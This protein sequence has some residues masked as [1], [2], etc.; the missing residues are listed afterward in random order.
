MDILHKL[1]SL[2]IKTLKKKKSIIISDYYDLICSEMKELKINCKFFKERMENL[3]AREYIKRD[4][5]DK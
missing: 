3:I 2:M 4:E 1:E 5:N